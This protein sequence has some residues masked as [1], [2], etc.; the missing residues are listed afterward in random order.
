MYP[1][2]RGGKGREGGERERLRMN[3]GEVGVATDTRKQTDKK[4]MNIL[5]CVIPESYQSE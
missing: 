3:S 2:S 5:S 1:K 4:V